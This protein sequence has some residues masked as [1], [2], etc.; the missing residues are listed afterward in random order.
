MIRPNITCGVGGVVAKDVKV[1]VIRLL[2][3]VQ[4]LAFLCVTEA[5]KGTSPIKFLLSLTPIGTKSSKV[6]WIQ[7]DRESNTHYIISR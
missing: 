2:N 4:K 5:V 1:G 7:T 6:C 3:G